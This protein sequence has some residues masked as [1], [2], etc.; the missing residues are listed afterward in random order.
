MP[1]IQLSKWELIHKLAKVFSYKSLYV[2]K[3]SEVH[4]TFDELSDIRV[5]EGRKIMIAGDYG[6]LLSVVKLTDHSYEV[7]LQGLKFRYNGEIDV[8]IFPFGAVLILGD[9]DEDNNP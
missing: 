5:I 9:E 8:H 1:A 2:V 6:Q 3:E 4:V 7:E